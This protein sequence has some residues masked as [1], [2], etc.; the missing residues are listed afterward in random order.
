MLQKLMI[1]DDEKDIVN[2]LVRVLGSLEE[3]S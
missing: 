1:V 2:A 3:L